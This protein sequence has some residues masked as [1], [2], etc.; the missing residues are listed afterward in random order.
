M[1]TADNHAFFTFWLRYYLSSGDQIFEQHGEVIDVDVSD[2][3]IAGRD[4]V[5]YISLPA[6][7]TRADGD[8]E[9]LARGGGQ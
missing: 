7:R 8:F 4:G 9:H 3:A 6:R 2:P 1:S 5:V